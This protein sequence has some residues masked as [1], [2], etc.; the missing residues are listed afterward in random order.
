[1]T[2]KPVLLIPLLC[3]KCSAPVPARIDEVAWACPTCGQGLLLDLTPQGNTAAIAQEIFY[4][5]AIQPGASG[6]PFWV[7]GGQVNITR[8]DTYKGNE[9]A[10]AQQFWATPRLFYIPGWAASL[11]EV[12][13]TG[14]Q[15]LKQPFG[16]QAGA[17]T[18]FKPIVTLPVDLQALAEFMVTS[19]EAGRS[20]WVKH[21][22]FTLTLLPPQLWILP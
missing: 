12:I 4:S 2:T 7:S 1:M 5:S 10:K 8:R 3:V 9:T 13:N 15:L 16:M 18:P 6:R 19:I 11:D 17:P 14:V 20:D 21:V 22:D